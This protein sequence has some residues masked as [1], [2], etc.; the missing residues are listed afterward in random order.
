MLISNGMEHLFFLLELLLFATLR[1]TSRITSRKGE[2]TNDS[3][4]ANHC[5]KKKCQSKCQLALGKRLMEGIWREWRNPARDGRNGWPRHT[6]APAHRLGTA[7]TQTSR[8]R[9][10]KQLLAEAMKN[11][12][13]A[14]TGNAMFHARR[15]TVNYC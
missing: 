2:A 6:H 1:A 15:S 4:G 5:R 10:R 12:N 9:Y 7:L 11:A 14:V 13:N 3:A 8:R